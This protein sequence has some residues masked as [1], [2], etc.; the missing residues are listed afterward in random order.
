M[1]CPLYHIH[2]RNQIKTKF[3]QLSIY[4]N[5]VCQVLVWFL[6]CSRIRWVIWRCFQWVIWWRRWLGIRGNFDLLSCCMEMFLF[7]CVLY[8]GFT[9]CWSS[10]NSCFLFIQASISACFFRYYAYSCAIVIRS[11]YLQAS[12]WC[13]RSSS[14]SWFLN[15]IIMTEYVFQS[16][17]RFFYHAKISRRLWMLIFVR[18]RSKIQFKIGFFHIILC[19]RLIHTKNTILQNFNLQILRVLKNFLKE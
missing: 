9:H 4:F 16:F 10:G 12:S 8:C 3:V 19:W 18:V 13:W 17:L 2:Q 1:L 6:P 11:Y 14:L 7:L 5:V 15:I